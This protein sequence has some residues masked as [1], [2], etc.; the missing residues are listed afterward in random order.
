MQK[1]SMS[2]AKKMV[3]AADSIVYL[4]HIDWPKRHKGEKFD[5]ASDNPD[6]SHVLLNGTIKWGK[7]GWV[8]ALVLSKGAT[9]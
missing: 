6:C 3:N 4:M 7:P 1:I 9:E 8:A 2:E 5:L